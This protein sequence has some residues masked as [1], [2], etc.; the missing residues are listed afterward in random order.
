[1]IYDHLEK[2][3][4]YSAVSNI[5]KITDFLQNDS[6]SSLPLGKHQIEGE[7]LFVVIDEYE[8]VDSEQK[9]Y[10]GHRQYIDL[11]LV[12]KG[13]EI[14]KHCPVRL[15]KSIQSY[16]AKRD[17]EF[18]SDQRHCLD[19]PMNKDH[20][21]VFMPQDGHKPGCLTSSSSPVRKAVFKI[22]I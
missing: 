7:H 6:L 15:L 16:N 2:L 13:E 18:F 11:Q 14:I 12:I 19:L 3:Y 8:T 1:M 4:D 5:S 21:A 22:R 20:F 17:V 10:E 9:N